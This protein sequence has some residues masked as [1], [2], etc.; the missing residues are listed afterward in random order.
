LTVATASGST[1]KTAAKLIYQ[2]AKKI[3]AYAHE[4]LNY[5]G[6]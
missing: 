5:T 2:I 1:A 6:L 4:I 3:I